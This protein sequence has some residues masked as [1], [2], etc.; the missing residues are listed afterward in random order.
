MSKQYLGEQDVDTQQHPE[1]KTWTSTDYAMY[2]IEQYGQFD[3]AHRKAWVLD[4]VARI[5]KGCAVDVK[6]ARW[7]HADGSIQTEYRLRL[8]GE[9]APEYL[10]WREEMKG[11][12]DSDGEPV[13]DYDEGI[14]C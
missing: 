7:Q 12:V 9:T 11:G 8:S 1:F 13:Y 10:A 5:L 6:L 4:Q 3:G 2:Y 14:P